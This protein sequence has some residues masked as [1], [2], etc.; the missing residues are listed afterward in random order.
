MGEV[1]VGRGGG[2]G[3]GVQRGMGEADNPLCLL[4]PWGSEGGWGFLG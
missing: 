1:E 2:R 3:E 4:W